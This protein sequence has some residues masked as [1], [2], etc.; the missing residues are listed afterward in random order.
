[1]ANCTTRKSRWPS[2]PV[3]R[4]ALTSWE[5][6]VGVPWAKGTAWVQLASR[7]VPITRNPRTVLI[8]TSVW[9]AL[10]LA[11]LR[12]APTESLMASRPV[13]DEPPLAKARS[14]WM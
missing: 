14:S 2:A 9:R 4:T 1:M 8:A 6:T 10:R 13:S 5:T 11:G 12:K 7:A 3:P